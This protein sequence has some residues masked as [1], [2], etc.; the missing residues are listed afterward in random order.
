M[1]FSSQFL[2]ILSDATAFVFLTCAIE[3]HGID[4]QAAESK[5]AFSALL[6]ETA[7][8]FENSC[9]RKVPL[10]SQ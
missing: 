5:T 8:G 7:D 9:V 3:L 10:L 1:V 2:M 6:T 4:V